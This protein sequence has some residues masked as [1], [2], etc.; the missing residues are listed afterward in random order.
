MDTRT[1]SARPADT[2]PAALRGLVSARATARVAASVPPPADWAAQLGGL[3]AVEQRRIL[4][5]LVRAQAAAVLGQSDP[6]RIEPDRGFLEIGI[7]SLTAVELRNRLASATGLRLPPTLIFDHSSPD[8]LAGFLHAELAPEETD[9]LAPAL[10]EID[11]LER[12]LLAAAQDET[13]RGALATRLRL[14]TSR[15]VGVGG[16]AAGGD[17]EGTAVP[18]LIQEASVEEIFDFIDRKLGRNAAK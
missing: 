4:L 12:S 5:N 10:G 16:G 8:G 18:G 2:L 3:P 7:D 14:T 13:A 15:L 9:A 17:R 11:R 1:L 6:S